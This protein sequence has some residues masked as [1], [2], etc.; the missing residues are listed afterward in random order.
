M[1]RRFCSM[2]H[3]STLLF[4]FEAPVGKDSV[5]GVDGPPLSERQVKSMVGGHRVHLQLFRA[6]GRNR[7]DLQVYLEGPPFPG[8]AVRALCTRTLPYFESGVVTVLVGTDSLVNAPPRLVNFHYYYYYYYYYV[9]MCIPPLK[10]Y[11]ADFFYRLLRWRASSAPPCPPLS[12]SSS[13][14]WGGYARPFSWTSTARR[15]SAGAGRAPRPPVSSRKRGV[16]GGLC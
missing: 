10:K 1:M 15:A 6:L 3:S 16:W 7:V 4:T 5:L 2:P 11:R 14:S 9:R 13:L 8:Y 12:R